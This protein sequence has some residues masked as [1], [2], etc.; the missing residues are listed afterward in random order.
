[1]PVGKAD[2][3]LCVKPG[4]QSNAALAYDEDMDRFLILYR[5]SVTNDFRVLPGEG[6]M[7]IGSKGDIK[8]TLYGVR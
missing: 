7:G 8:G 6:P 5:D 1:M 2:I 4:Y 3:P